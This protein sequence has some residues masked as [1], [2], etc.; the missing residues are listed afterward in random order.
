MTSQTFCFPTEE[1]FGMNTDR[2]MTLGAL[3]DVTNIVAPRGPDDDVTQ[4]GN[5]HYMIRRRATKIYV[6][7]NPRCDTN[8]MLSIRPKDIK[9]TIK[10][11]ERIFDKVWRHR[12]AIV[13]EV[14]RGI[15][16]RRDLALVW[17]RDRRKLVTGFSV[18]HQIPLNLSG[19]ELRVHLDV[20]QFQSTPY[21]YVNNETSSI[22][23]LFVERRFLNSCR[24]DRFELVVP[25]VYEMDFLFETNVFKLGCKFMKNFRV[26]LTKYHVL[27]KTIKMRSLKLL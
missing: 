21:C 15:P 20:W 1:E 12:K 27:C 17:S 4:L 18:S 24:E 10:S 11:L 22:Q 3:S 26:L 25:E 16:R 13:R 9:T 14:M 2:R 8:I 5:N 7:W 23:E 6:R 19:L